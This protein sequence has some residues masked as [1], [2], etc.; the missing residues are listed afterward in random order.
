MKIKGCGATLCELWGLADRREEGVTPDR[1]N[2]I[3]SFYFKYE[4]LWY[5]VSDGGFSDFLKSVRKTKSTI[6]G[7]F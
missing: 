2:E 7:L 5:F 6:V 3:D 1:K 4:L